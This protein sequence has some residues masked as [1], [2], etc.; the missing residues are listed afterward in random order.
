MSLW[1]LGKIPLYYCNHA[2]FPDLNALESTLTISSVVKAHEGMYRCVVSN[3]AGSVT[4]DPAQLTVCKLF[5]LCYCISSY[6]ASLSSHIVD[7][8]LPFYIFTVVT[9]PKVKTH[10]TS[11]LMVVPG[12]SA[13]FTISV[14]AIPGHEHTYQWQKNE[15]DIPGATSSTLTI[16][17]VVKANK[18]TY[19]CVATNAAGPVT[20]DP[21]QLTVC[22]LNLFILLPDCTTPIDDLSLP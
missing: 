6:V 4:S 18:G 16:S 11:E 19:R 13:T 17:S 14:I 15:R 12:N 5:S 21:A 20:S 8:S 22:K 7:H 1:E 9:P 2:A 3:A 10:P